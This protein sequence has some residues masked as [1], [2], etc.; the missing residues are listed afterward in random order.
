MFTLTD[1]NEGKS[2]TDKSSSKILQIQMVLEQGTWGCQNGDYRYADLGKPLAWFSLKQTS[3][4][5]SI[6]YYL[7]Y[8]MRDE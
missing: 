5:G 2:N 4:D 3:P 6:E 7:D 8:F 1:N